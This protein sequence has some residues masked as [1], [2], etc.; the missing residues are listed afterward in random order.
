MKSESFVCGTL[1]ECF[2][3]VFSNKKNLLFSR[4]SSNYGPPMHQGG[5]MGHQN[6]WNGPPRPNGPI[7]PPNGPPG[8]PQHRPMVSNI[9]WILISFR[10]Q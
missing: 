1:S 7:R 9:S 10:S 6:Q 3:N 2:G 8:P 5:P 4:P